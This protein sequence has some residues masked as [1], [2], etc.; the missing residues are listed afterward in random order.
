MNIKSFLIALLIGVVA[1]VI[2]KLISHFYSI[3]DFKQGLFVGLTTMAAYFI[4]EE[5]FGHE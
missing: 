2:L 1:M 4:S 5:Y 3:A